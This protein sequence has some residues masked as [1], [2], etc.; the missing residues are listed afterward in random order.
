MRNA[1]PL[2]LTLSLAAALCPRAGAVLTMGTLSDDG[3]GGA[4]ASQRAPGGTKDSK[5]QPQKAAPEKKPAPKKAVKKTWKRAGKKAFRKKKKKAGGPASAYKFSDVDGAAVYKLDRNGNPITGPSA[6]KR[7]PSA[8]K[9]ERPSHK[10]TRGKPWT[11]KKTAGKAARKK[12]SAYKF[13]DVDGAA[14]YKLDRNANPIVR[15]TRKQKKGRYGK[16]GGAASGARA[17]AG[18]A[19]KLEPAKPLDYQEPPAGQAGQQPNGGQ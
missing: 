4:A 14:V 6:H 2:L 13:S 12:A 9:K 10:K 17:P 15:K 3:T 19:A 1:F 7:K 16:K 11:R 18:A 5:P 8:K